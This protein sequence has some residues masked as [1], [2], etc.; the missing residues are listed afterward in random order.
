MKTFD[1]LQQ[2]IAGAEEEFGDPAVPICQLFLRWTSEDLLFY[3]GD[4][5]AVGLDR[6]R[7]PQYSI[8][9]AKGASFA[10]PGIAEAPD[11]SDGS[12]KAF[13]AQKIAPGIWSLNPSLNL[14]MLL[15][16]F[17]VFYGVPDP[18]PWELAIIMPGRDLVGP[19]RTLVIP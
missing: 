2:W 19:D 9:L 13:G 14:P 12:I 10:L 18:A 4:D 8:A 17:I 11:I 16:A 6:G 15:H 5:L 7:R 3:K 1:E